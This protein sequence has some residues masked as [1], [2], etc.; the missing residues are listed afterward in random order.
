MEKF[1]TS[2]ALK[3]LA[4]YLAITCFVIAGIP[5]DSLAYLVESQPASYS[6]VADMDKIQRVLESKMVSQRLQELGLS[7]DEINSKLAGLGDAEIH[8]FASRL[9]SL[10]PGGD[11]LIDIMALLVIAILVLVILHLL[12]YKVIIK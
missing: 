9:D 6:R 8:Q 2:L 10:M 1:R 3:P 7:T 5:R 12:G 11:M 4:L